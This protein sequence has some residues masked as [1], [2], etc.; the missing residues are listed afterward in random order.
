[1]K[2]LTQV[3]FTAILAMGISTAAIAQSANDNVPA[4]ATVEAPIS[5][6]GN[7][8]VDYGT[9]TTGTDDGNNYPTTAGYF[10]VSATAT[11]SVNLSFSKTDLT[12]ASA[13][14][15]QTLVMTLATS[16]TADGAWEDGLSADWTNA[17]TAGTTFFL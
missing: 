16:G 7:Q 12:T 4:N 17:S 3:L 2:R 5:V 9:L 10:T 13:G 8:A 1:M 11:S 15:D 6:T 14:S